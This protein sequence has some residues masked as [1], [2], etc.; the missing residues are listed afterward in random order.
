MINIDRHHLPT[1]VPAL[2]GIIFH[3]LDVVEGQKQVIAKQQATIE[4]QQEVIAAQQET[5]KAQQQQIEHLTQRVET[6]EKQLYGKRS[7][8]RSRNLSAP[9]DKSSKPFVGHGRRVLPD[10]L[11]RVR[12]EHELSTDKK[13]CAECGGALSKIGDMTSEQLD[14]IPSQLYVIQHV[15]HKYAC[16][17]CQ[18]RVTTAPMPAQPLDKG[19]PAPGL[20]AEV[21]V[22]KY[23]DALPLYR[24]AQRFKRAGLMINRSTLCEWIMHSASLL[25]PLVEWMAQHHLKPSGH[26]HTDDTP[27]RL[28]QNSEDERETGRFWIYTSKGKE[29][30]PACTVYQ[31]TPHRRASAPNTFLKDFKGYL[32]ADAYSGYDELYKEK[33]GKP[34]NVTEVACWAHARRYFINSAIG[35]AQDNP[36]HTALDYIGQLYTLEREGRNGRLDAQSLKQFRME[37][38]PPILEEFHGWLQMQKMQVLPKSTLA[39]AI[40]YT[41]NHWQALNVYRTEGHL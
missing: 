36:V 25:Y 20:L 16:R 33:D 17:Q 4:K 10:H 12:E 1:D 8:R 15:R 9:I 3:L 38:A 39:T 31:F 19:L 13:I 37:R 6:L 29:G 28:L 2:H 32:Q 7:E 14:C 23:H 41:L 34:S 22:N 24:Q 11:P 35:A 30:Y 18:G 26:I 5:I 27:I 21:L 40:N